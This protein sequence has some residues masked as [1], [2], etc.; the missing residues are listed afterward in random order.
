MEFERFLRYSLRHNRPVRVLAQQ[1]TMRYMNLTVIAME[2]D[3]F[4]FRKAA[5]AENFFKNIRAQ[6][7][8]LNVYDKTFMR[9]LHNGPSRL[10]DSDESRRKGEKVFETSM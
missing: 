1:E 3:V 8:I 5:P 4:S 9:L 10:V 6:R 7:Y 2:E